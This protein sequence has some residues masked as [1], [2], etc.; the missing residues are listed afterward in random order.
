MGK[1]AAVRLIDFYIVIF[2]LFIAII[3]ILGTLSSFFDPR[4]YNVIPFTGLFLPVLLVIDLISFIYLILSRRVIFSCF[5]AAVLI[6][7]SVGAGYK[8]TNL[9]HPKINPAGDNIRVMTFNIGGNRIGWKNQNTLKEMARFIKTENIDILCIQEYPSNE[10]ACESLRK[11]LDFLPFRAF[12]EKEGGYLKI[13]VFSRFPIQNTKCILF[14][15]SVN[16]A[17]FTDLTIDNKTVRLVSAHMQTTSLKENQ[18]YSGWNQP[19]TIYQAIKNLNYN[20][21]MRASQANL[22]KDEIKLSEFPVI[23]CGDMNDP[24]TSYTYKIIKSGLK[25]GFEECG[26]GIGHTFQG[27]F[28]LLRID[29]ILYSNDFT[30]IKYYS[31]NQSFSDHNPVIMDLILK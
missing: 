3:T 1:V 11:E 25:D 7:G 13:A 5:I 10:R 24:P 23:F 8:L 18:I 26:E 16:N 2:A 4:C 15:N 17:I 12:T 14:D 27:F 22:I 20:L 6:F 31:P 21:K 28:N 19:N 29:Y 9:F 30:G